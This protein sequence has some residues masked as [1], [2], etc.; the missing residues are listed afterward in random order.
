MTAPSPQNLQIVANKKESP[1]QKMVGMMYLVLMAML[2]LNVQREVLNAFV[3]LNDGN[4]QSFRQS[5]ASAD[6]ALGQLRFANG[7]DPEK[8]GPYFRSA[9]SIH[10]ASDSLI[11]WIEGLRKTLIA[12]EEGVEP[13]VADT[14]Q[15]RYAERL[16]RYDACTRLLMGDKEDGSQGMARALREQVQTYVSSVHQTL[17]T[18]GLPAPAS[19]FDFKDRTVEG[20]SLSWEHATF[21]DTPLAACV[22]ILNKYKSDARNLEVAALN[23]LRARIDVDDIPVDTV[24]AKVNPVSNYVTLGESFRAD[25][26]LGAYSTTSAPEVV[27]GEV[28]EDG[29]L[30]GDG[31]AIP[32]TGGVGTV[33]IK[34]TRTGEHTVTGEVRIRDK[35]GQQ[36]RYPFAQTYLVAQPTAVVAPS[37]M[38]V[39]YIGPENPLDIS[40]PGIPDE[41]IRVRVSGGNSIRKVAPGKF[42]CTLEKHS[43]RQV[44]VTVEAVLEDGTTRAFGSS[45]FRVRNLPKPE[46]RIA[47]VWNTGGLNE[48][49]FNYFNQLKPAYGSDFPFQL[50]LKVLRYTVGRQV[51]PSQ[52]SEHT[53]QGGNF[54]R[55]TKQMFGAC[56]PREKLYFTNILVEGQ[57]GLQHEVNNLTV[58]RE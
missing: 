39:L 9:E 34:P 8:A 54:D 18:H 38:N 1:R 57:D 10:H 25:V 32:V 49:E 37:K 31:N 2:A 24:L 41:N 11:A 27:I 30:I 15:L 23:A 35:Q 6:A 36:R 50:P 40:V 58:V 20:E 45:P 4:N 47:D 52:Y 16:D 17:S 14:L 21:Y 19:P 3:T 43:P 51:S 42:V 55:K 7:V 28:G 26:F 56:R 46:V 29:L 44:N 5:S 33:E 12:E 13:Q 22:P 48:A 53:V